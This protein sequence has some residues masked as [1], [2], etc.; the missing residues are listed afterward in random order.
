MKILTGDS[1]TGGL[2]IG[3]YFGSLKKRVELQNKSK[4]FII[5]ADNQAFLNI[6]YKVIKKNIYEI[7]L[8]YLSVGI[9]PKKTT[10]FIQ[11]CIKEINEFYF[12][13]LKFVTYKR[14]IRNPT[15]KKEINTK[16]ISPNIAFLTYPI[17][18]AADILS[19]MVDYTIVGEDQ[20]PLIEQCN[21]IGKK[22][23][24]FIG[25]NFFKKCNIIYGE[26]KKLIGIYGKN[27]MSKSL[28][29]SID[30]NFSDKDINFTVNKIY[31]DPNRIRSDIEGNIKNNVLFEYLKLFLDK[32]KYSTYIKYYKIGRIRDSFLKEKLEYEIKEFLKP[33]RIRRKFFL[34][35]KKILFK[36]IKDGNKKAKLIVKN[37]LL[38]LKKILNRNY[39]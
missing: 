22:F 35:R 4:L 38:K 5:I 37:N 12:L 23:N 31:T 1:P 29:N 19:F 26:K 18:Q 2:H 28:K 6:N 34:K 9:D 20:K 3:H 15:I 30:L 8:D 39:F 36:I 17:S 13:F 25:K 24:N 27:K 14:L 21:E 33:I 16:N 32:D 7:L 11:S 10:I